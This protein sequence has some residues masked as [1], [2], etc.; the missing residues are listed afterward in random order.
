MPSAPPTFCASVRVPEA[1]DSVNPGGS[2]ADAT[3]KVTAVVC[4]M[5]FEEPEPLVVPLMVIE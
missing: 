2:G 3:T 1:A 4:L 5:P